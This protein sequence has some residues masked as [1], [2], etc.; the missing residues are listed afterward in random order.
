M[1]G[2]TS[3]ALCEDVDG[4]PKLVHFLAVRESP[5]L[6][7][8]ETWDAMGMRPTG[9]HDIVME[10][11][12]VP[13]ELV[14]AERPVGRLDEFAINSHKWFNVTFGAVYTGV[15]A[16]ARDYA[17]EYA[18]DRV[19]KP[20]TRSIGHFPSIQY[21]VA[22]MDV[23]LESSRAIVWKAATEL[24]GA[25]ASTARELADALKAK[26]VATNNAIQ[27]VDKAMAVLGGTGF[28]KRTP[29]ERL[30]RDVRGATIHPPTHYDALEIIGK[31]ALD[32]PLDFEPRW[33]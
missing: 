17:V 19:R 33:G 7:L 4:E 8:V 11:V 14:I 26:Y 13:N 27:V 5:G 25:P 23:L 16:G 6:E 1:T 32:V 21:L 18:R 30:Y 12:F 20:Y 15:A 31:A 22:E 29:L 2:F 24:G 28:L 10:D 3:H 9:S